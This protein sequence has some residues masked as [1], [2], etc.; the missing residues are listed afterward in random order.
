MRK[1]SSMVNKELQKDQFR[2]FCDFVSKLQPKEQEQFF[3]KFLSKSEKAYLAQ[4]LNIM[5]MI[6]KKFDYFDI[7]NKLHVPKATISRAKNLLEENDDLY[8]LI[9]EYKY[10]EENI[11]KENFKKEK[12]SFVKAHYPGAIKID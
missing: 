7:Q 4:R 8:R 6:T 12:S 10:K 1:V 11:N 5:R 2:V 9:S 3:S